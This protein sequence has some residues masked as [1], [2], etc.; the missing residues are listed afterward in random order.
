MGTGEVVP[1]DREDWEY[2]A[3]NGE[4]IGHSVYG[5]GG[6]LTCHENALALSDVSD[7]V[8]TADSLG[9]ECSRE[10]RSEWC[11]AP[12]VPTVELDA[13]GKH[14]RF[15]KDL[16]NLNKA[17]IKWMRHEQKG[18]LKRTETEDRIKKSIVA[19]KLC[20]AHGPSFKL[21]RFVA[22]AIERAVRVPSERNA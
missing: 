18:Q 19:Q 3:D 13:H 21:E 2:L 22:Q 4:D 16:V 20:A 17:V 8:S 10:Q 15:R 11:D 9:A 14:S 6:V 7:D 12:V 5:Q 1:T